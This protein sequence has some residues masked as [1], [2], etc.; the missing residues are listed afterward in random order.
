MIQT[1]PKKLEISGKQLFITD[2]VQN[3][4]IHVA[5][6]STL[7]MVALLSKGFEDRRKLN[8]HVNGQNSTVNFIGIV[9]ADGEE[10]FPFETASNHYVPNTQAFYYLRSAMFDKAEIDYKGNLII[11]KEA[12]QTDSYLAHNT[13]MLSKKAK[14][15]TMPCLEIE[16]DDV[17]AGHAAAIGKVDDEL[18]FYLESRGIDR[19]QGQ[20][21]LIK[22]FLEADL[23]MIDSEEARTFIVKEIDK[24]LN[25]RSNAN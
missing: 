6:N 25:A 7:T 12:Q 20:E 11:K 2:E 4:E 14:T 23:N 15:N 3:S 9:I 24:K 19:K 16:A 21:M 13:L 18:L 10:N 1:L 5:E 22:G 8:F 17:K